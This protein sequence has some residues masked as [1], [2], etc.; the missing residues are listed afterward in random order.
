[1]EV[2]ILCRRSVHCTFFWK[3][4]FFQTN[5]KTTLNSVPI[6][7]IDVVGLVLLGVEGESKGGSCV[8]VSILQFVFICISR[9]GNT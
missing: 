5:E 9:K 1:M 4:I 6:T 3:Y 7:T 2:Y 8:A